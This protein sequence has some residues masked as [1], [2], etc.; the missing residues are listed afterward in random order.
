MAL[1]T[2]IARLFRADFHAVL[3]QI[4]SPDIL[5]KQAIR[6]MQEHIDE[7]QQKIKR[8]HLECK[9]LK[10]RES[11]LKQTIAQIENDL[12]VCFETDNTEL[13]RSLIRRKL[14]ACYF[15]HTLH[16]KYEELGQVE[17][18]L[19]DQRIENSSQLENI[20]QKAEILE[21]ENRSGIADVGVSPPHYSVSDEEIEVAF[22]REQQRRSPS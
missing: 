4:E 6:E 2:R 11:E 9:R 13:A 17:K 12:E 19:Q 5:L 10:T 18:E 21:Q 8:I 15:C 20:Q 3:D 14:E 7:N 16:K 22:L 1:I